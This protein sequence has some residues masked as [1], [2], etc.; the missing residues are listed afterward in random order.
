[1]LFRSITNSVVQGKDPAVGLLGVGVGAAVNEGFDAIN[2]FTKA[3]KIDDAITGED[4]EGITK[5]GSAEGGLN[6]VAEND[7]KNE[8]ETSGGL[9]QM[10]DAAQADESQAPHTLTGEA[11]VDRAI[12]DIESGTST[13]PM[14][15]VTAKQ[16]DVLAPV[17]GLNQVA[18]AA[19]EFGP[20]QPAAQAPADVATE[21]AQVAPVTDEQK[22]AVIPTK[23]EEEKATTAQQAGAGALSG[24]VTSKLVSALK[25]Q[26]TS[27]ITKSLL[28]TKAPTRPQPSAQQMAAMKIAA[29]KPTRPPIQMDVSKLMPVK[30]TAPAPVVAPKQVNVSALTPIKGG[31]SLT[32]ILKN[33]KKAG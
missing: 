8:A 17:G 4:Q 23:T 24:A 21:V 5:T 30:R 31:S 32:S 10:L 3:G 33:I 7:A 25:P 14:D 15:Q 12:D 2:E 28:P 13:D 22:A 27:T 20:A 29:A 6:A 11:S 1:M 18:E 16:A 26:L 9:S 19:P